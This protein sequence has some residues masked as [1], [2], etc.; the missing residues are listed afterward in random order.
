MYPTDAFA[1]PF[2]KARAMRALRDEPQKDQTIADQRA[3]IRR[4]R[5]EIVRLQSRLKRANAENQDLRE[6]REIARNSAEK[7]DADFHVLAEVAKE[8]R[9]EAGLPKGELEKR[10]DRKR[11]ERKKG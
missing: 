3:E 2:I 1:H 10:F 5:E 6:A 9:A 8:F 4:L 11:A 7:A